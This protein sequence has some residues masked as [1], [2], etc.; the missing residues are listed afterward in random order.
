M[1]FLFG[2]TIDSQEMTN[3]FAQ[4]IIEHYLL[5]LINIVL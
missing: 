2:S 4:T 3:I 5:L 1:N